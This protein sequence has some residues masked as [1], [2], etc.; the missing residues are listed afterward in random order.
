M[1][2]SLYRGA[3]Q[4]TVNQNCTLH[5]IVVGKKRADILN[6]KPSRKNLPKKI[7]KGP[8]TGK[9]VVKICIY[10]ADNLY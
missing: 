9:I 4:W 8:N 1:N 2:S 3:I 10:E 6:K 7:K 5:F